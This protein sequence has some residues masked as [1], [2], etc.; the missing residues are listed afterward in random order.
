MFAN[1]TDHT[2]SGCIAAL[3]CERLLAEE[4]EEDSS[5]HIM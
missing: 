2:G 3:E 5:S 1:R 4:E